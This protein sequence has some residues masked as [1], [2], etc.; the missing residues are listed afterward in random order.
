MRG[1]ILLRDPAC[2]GE[3]GDHCAFGF[4]AHIAAGI[5]Q[6]RDKII[7][8]LAHL[9][10]LKVQKTNARKPVAV[11]QPQKVLG[12]EI[13]QDQDARAVG[14]GGH[15][16]QKCRVKRGGIGA[17]AGGGKGIPV[18]GEPCRLCPIRR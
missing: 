15:R 4:R 6:K 8:G 2:V 14:M 10:E 1:E 12:M 7:A 11:G 16:G 3:P 13:P 9:T 17:G 18:K 5:L